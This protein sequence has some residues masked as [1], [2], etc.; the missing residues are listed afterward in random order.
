MWTK[1]SEILK[2]A[3]EYLEGVSIDEVLQALPKM[4]ISVSKTQV[5]A[6]IKKMKKME[7]VSS[8][9][10]VPCQTQEHVEY[11]FD[12]E[13]LVFNVKALS[14]YKDKI[15]DMSTFLRVLAKDFALADGL[16]Q[17]FDLTIE[18]DKIA[19]SDLVRILKPLKRNFELAKDICEH[20][21]MV[22]RY[23]RDANSKTIKKKRR[24]P[25]SG[26]LSFSTVQS[27][28]ESIEM[29]ERQKRK[30]VEM[31]RE[32]AKK[33]AEKRYEENEKDC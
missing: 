3:K 29:T 26:I 25:I 15:S 14:I 2:F 11:E 22:E 6:Q 10:I 33:I 4:N 27:T 18:Q 13:A 19:T 5:M 9:Y 1:Q 23:I 8:K 28:D 16:I 20:G 12:Q 31:K 32:L 17:T 24:L 30:R 21:N 7:Q